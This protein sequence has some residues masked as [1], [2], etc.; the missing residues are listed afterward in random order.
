MSDPFDPANDPLLAELG[1]LG[2]PP[3]GVPKTSGAALLAQAAAAAPVVVGLAGAKLYTL[4]GAILVVGFGSGVF[5]TRALEEPADRHEVAAVVPVTDGM[6]P[7]DALVWKADPL[8]A[9][10]NLES[11]SVPRP[12]AHRESNGDMTSAA[13]QGI[14]APAVSGVGAVGSRASSSGRPPTS[15]LAIT[16]RRGECPEPATSS[17][18]E[19]GGFEADD[20]WI[21]DPA[22][23]AGPLAVIPGVDDERG[24][25]TLAQHDGQHDEI[26]DAGG[27]G[28]AP[29][30]RSAEAEREDAGASVS[31]A[32]SAT[33]QG[34]QPAE[35]HVRAGLGGGALLYPG[36]PAPDLG[37]AVGLQ[38]LTPGSRRAAG[39][40]ALNLDAGV[41]SQNRY[42]SGTLGV[43][44]EFGLAL[45][46]RDGLRFELSG[47]GGVRLLQ[48]NA[49]EQSTTLERPDEIPQDVWDRLSEEERRERGET[50]TS[51]TGP[52]AF[53]AFGARF[54][55]VVG[56]VG[57]P[58]S[59]RASLF[60]QAMLV[61]IDG[62]NRLSAVP[63][64]GGTLGLDILL[65]TPRPAKP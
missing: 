1:Q 36:S 25:S 2:V 9:A 28:T 50:S 52:S 23:G 57:S 17:G 7:R 44:G 32:Q 40:L 15:R 16:N 48:T 61:T 24:A 5:A 53:P 27:Y 18:A 62:A 43:D 38:L 8:G 45:R 35:G 65:P 31:T 26:D 3:G 11:P 51:A 14:H 49:D 59:F 58:L 10:R 4:L 47:I 12:D 30:R 37:I 22:P 33:R 39:V 41:A 6:A 54:G 21:P 13:V 20:S 19:G 34:L 60:G 63:A 56:R 29:E 42:T 46:P 55:V 64:I